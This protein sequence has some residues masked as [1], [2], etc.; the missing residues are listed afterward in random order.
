[1]KGF[2][3]AEIARIRAQVGQGR[4]ICGLSGGVDS[5][6]A[7]A[8][9]H[10]A[11]GDQLTCIFVDS[12]LLRLGEAEEVVRTWR[13]R[14]N[15]KLVHRDA[16]EL[17]LRELDGVADPEAKRK[18]IGRV[19]I[20]VFEEE[21]KRGRRRRLPR[22]RHALPRRD[23]EHQRPWRPQRHHQVAPQ[24]RRPARAD[25]HEAG[26]TPARTVQGR[27]PRIGPRARHPRN[28]SSA[29]TLSPAPASPSASPAR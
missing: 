14:F 28:A 22:P 3:D 13:D 18:T 20:E 9:I 5:S 23:R 17:F 12:G 15:I 2:R 4:V 24:R 1:M 26:R 25:A 29:A 10:E 11:I 6:V 16:S 27:G 8:I 21:A 19:F 7:A